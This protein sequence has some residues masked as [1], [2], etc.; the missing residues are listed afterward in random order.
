MLTYSVIKEIYD[1]IYKYKYGSFGDIDDL[2]LGLF[3]GLFLTTI[4]PFT[5]MLDSI[6]IIPK[7]IVL[8]FYKKI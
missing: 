6:L 2:L 1:N 7:I 8:I 4:I 5:I 3:L